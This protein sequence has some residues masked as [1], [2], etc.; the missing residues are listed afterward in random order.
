MITS[1]L[2]EKY[3]KH[4]KENYGKEYSVSQLLKNIDEVKTDPAHQRRFD[5][6]RRDLV[7]KYD[8]TW[9]EATKFAKDISKIEPEYVTDEIR[10]VW[11]LVYS[12]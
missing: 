3:G 7:F 2:R 12:P 11:D 8:M 5:K 10:D 1:T 9:D 4:W 6:A